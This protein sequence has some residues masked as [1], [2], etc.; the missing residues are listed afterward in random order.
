MDGRRGTSPARPLLARGRVRFV[1][2]PVAF[3]VADTLDQARDAAEAI[4]LDIDDRPAKVDVATGGEAVHDEAPDNV[5]YVWEK[6]DEA[7]VDAALAAAAHRVELVLDDNRVICASLEPRGVWAEETDGRLHV[8]V[9]GQGVWGTKTKLG[10]ILGLEADAIR[11]TNPD[12]GGGFGMKGMDYPE[13]FLVPHAARVLGRPV[14]WMGDRSESMLSDNAGRDLVCTATMGFDANRKLVAYKVEN[15]ANMGAYN[16]GYAQ[17]IQSE[18]F[19]KVM[20]GTYDVQAVFL[21]STGVYTNTTQVDAYR[22]AGRPEAIYTDRA[23]DGLRRSRAGRRPV[24]TCAAG[25]SSGPT[26]SP[27]CRRRARPTT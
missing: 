16:S 26:S 5:A 4:V 14:R 18:L 6:G 22:G 3:V 25:R 1:G 17:N 15:V 24:S 23:G 10:K 21:R 20:P 7:A 12:V 11:V 2:E 13:T 9:N 8:C 27:T 19:A